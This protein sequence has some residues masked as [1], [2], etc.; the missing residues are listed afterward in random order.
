MELKN[1]LARKLAGR[2]ISIRLYAGVRTHLVEPIDGNETENDWFAVKDEDKEGSEP[3][4]YTHL[5]V[6]KRQD[7]SGSAGCCPDP[8]DPPGP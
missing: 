2:L 3:V 5:D 6:Y 7:C 8:W 4:S 1:K